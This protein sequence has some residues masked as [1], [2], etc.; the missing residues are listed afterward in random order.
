MDL[1]GAVATVIERDSRPQQT[2]QAVREVQA[3]FSPPVFKALPIQ[4]QRDICNRA[5]G[6]PNS[7]MAI[8]A[9]WAAPTYRWA[10]PNS[11]PPFCSAVLCRAS[12]V[13]QLGKGRLTVALQASLILSTRAP[14]GRHHPSRLAAEAVN[15]IVLACH[16]PRLG[17][18]LLRLPSRPGQVATSSVE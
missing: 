15:C 13:L 18:P 10:K 3:V 5:R 8:L 16:K 14:S 4:P 9:K 11:Y 12:S 2:L 7:Q 6:R 17:D 1:K